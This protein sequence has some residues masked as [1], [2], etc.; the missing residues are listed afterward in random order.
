[1]IEKEFNRK[2]INLS[3][4]ARYPLEYKLV[5]LERDAIEGDI[6]ILALEYLH[7]SYRYIPKNFYNH[8]F[9]SL[10]FYYYNLSF[11]DKIKLIY[12]TPLTSIIYAYKE[13]HQKLNRTKEFIKKF[14]NKDRGDKIAKFKTQLTS[15]A[16]KHTCQEYIFKDQIRYGFK[17]SNI[18]KDNIKKIKELEKDKKIKF[19]I[20]YPAVAG[21]NCYTTQYSKDFKEFNNK[22]KNILKE[23]NITLLGNYQDSYFK[24]EYQ[25]NTYY[26]IIEKAREIR[27][28]RLIKSLREILTSKEV[29]I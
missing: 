10:S 3:D 24:K 27:T 13:Q 28:K 8:L 12:K 7:Y 2:T 19:F 20:I 22:I 29:S 16:K 5:R 23:N 17:I 9:S 4:N 26:H 21:D 25:Y 11:Q 1:M 15:H 14:Q 18:F 6:I